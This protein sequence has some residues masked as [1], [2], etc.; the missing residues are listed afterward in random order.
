MTTEPTL[1][2]TAV[3]RA[4]EKTEALYVEF[5]YDVEQ[6]YGTRGQVKVM[7]TYDGIPYRGS[8]AKMGMDCHFLLI[9]KDI[10]KQIGKSPGDTIRVTVQRDV[11]ARIVEIPEDLAAAFVT[12]PEAL[13]RFNGLS[14]TNRK[15]Y[16][17]WLTDAKRPETRARRLTDTIEKLLAGRKNPSDKG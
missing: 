1:E 11:A 6:R 2:F 14:Y 3:L 9:R 5:P 8:L 17:A 10:C 12:A 16:A 13:A 7:V 4:V 15:E